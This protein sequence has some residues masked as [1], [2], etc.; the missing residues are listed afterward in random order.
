MR[1]TQDSPNTRATLL[2]VDLAGP[3][4]ARRHISDPA[5]A[6]GMRESPGG[7]H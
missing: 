5:G 4:A 1:G 6:S 2:R 7:D 3:P